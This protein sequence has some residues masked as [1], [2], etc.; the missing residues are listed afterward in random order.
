MFLIF[1]AFGV[2]RFKVVESHCEKESKLRT[3]FSDISEKKKNMLK[4]P[5]RPILIGKHAHRKGNIKHVRS[6]SKA[7]SVVFLNRNWQKSQRLSVP[8]DRQTLSMH[9][10]LQ[11]QGL[12]RSVGTPLK[13]MYW[14]RDR[15][16]S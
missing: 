3:A 11:S 7:I 8:T 14:T 4:C 2:W 6:W 1:M 5:F 16:E 9:Q 12:R 13:Y 15:K 10:Y